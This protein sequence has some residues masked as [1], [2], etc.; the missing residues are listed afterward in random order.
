MKTMAEMQ[1][2]DP[3]KID[4][5]SII[6]SARELRYDIKNWA[7]AQR[8]V[9][10]LPAQG[11]LSTYANRALGG[12]EKGPNYEFLK[13]VTPVFHDYTE[14]P[15]DFK[16]LLQAYVWKR[17]VEMIFYEDLW[18]GI[19]KALDDEEVEY[20][21]LQGYRHMKSNLTPSKILN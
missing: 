1:S 12:K 11:L 8:P 5:T 7:R 20:K 3:F 16:W 14:S 17:I 2:A 15:Q 6:S 10:S 4:N 9:P 21:L 13:D 19:R 18:A